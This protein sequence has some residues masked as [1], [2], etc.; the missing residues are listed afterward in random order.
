MNDTVL[1]DLA[2]EEC[3]RLLRSQSV[4]R[5]A[6]VVDEFPIV[7]PVNYRLAEMGHRTWIVVR[8]RPGNVLDRASMHVAFEIDGI[9]PVHRQGW[10]VLARGTLRHLDPGTG[11]FATC[12]DPGPWVASER[13]AWLVIEPLVITGR[14]LRAPEFEWALH[15]R[16]VPLKPGHAAVALALP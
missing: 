3:L 15:S 16:D 9:D 11:D 10:S 12:F 1:E 13:D 14:Q 6:V 4:G 7:V 5:I 8:T 2:Q